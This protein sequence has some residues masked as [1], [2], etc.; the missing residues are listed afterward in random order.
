MTVSKKLGKLNILWSCNEC[1]KTESNKSINEVCSEISDMNMHKHQ[2][3]YKALKEQL[4]SS[5]FV[6]KTLNEDLLTAR[7]E[8]KKYKEKN[9][10]WSISYFYKLKKLSNLKSK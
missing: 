3:H 1:V 9:L 5:E 4:K 8:I 6:I 7:T 10:T 2:L